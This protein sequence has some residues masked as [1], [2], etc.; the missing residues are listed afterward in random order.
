MGG[1][2]FV[3][4][5]ASRHRDAAWKFIQYFT[6][7]AN[8]AGYVENSGQPARTDALKEYAAKAPLFGALADSLPNGVYQPGWLRDQSGFYQALGTQVSL[9]LTGQASVE[10][11]LKQ[12]QADCTSVLRQSGDLR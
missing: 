8:M 12:A 2:G 11:A 7:K 6:T 3:I 4:P 10:E 1:F 9:A 5:H